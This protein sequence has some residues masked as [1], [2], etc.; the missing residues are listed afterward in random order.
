MENHFLGK[1]TCLSSSCTLKNKDLYLCIHKNCNYSKIICEECKNI[2]ETHLSDVLLLSEYL[3][4]MGAPKNEFKEKLKSSGLWI[5]DDEKI[6]Q[7][8]NEGV[9]DDMKRI[10]EI[11]LSFFKSIRI[12][13]ERMKN[14]FK[15]KIVQKRNDE[16]NQILKL[17]KTKIKSIFS[18]KEMINLIKHPK[19]EKNLNSEE[20]RILT[21]NLI[22]K[23][24]SYS[25]R[26]KNFDFSFLDGLNNKL[27][28]EQIFAPFDFSDSII[29][30]THKELSSTILNL[31]SLLID[32]NNN[33]ENSEIKEIV[34]RNI[35]F[36]KSL[37][38]N[39]NS[40]LNSIKIIDNYIFS[41]DISGKIVVWS[42]PK[43]N[44]IE[45][46][47]SSPYEKAVNFLKIIPS[48]KIQ[49]DT[50]DNNVKKIK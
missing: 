35:S 3:N 39:H 4:N 1:I 48:N 44:E 13:L 23:I 46:S 36:Y 41:S 22:E 37:P 20:Q 17:Y 49:N 47:Y 50:D 2:H 26:I 9:K 29:S 8:A 21:Q 7:I 5:F 40:F 19:N 31:P 45:I 32:N 28:H 12:I 14:E 27:L 25:S 24:D 38:S 30:K 6:S 34:P 18:T 42:F 33:K 15:Q 10:D 11:Y 16:I 43:M